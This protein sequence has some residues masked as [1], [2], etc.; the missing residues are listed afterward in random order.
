MFTSGPNLWLSATSAAGNIWE[1]PLASVAPESAP[2]VA[3]ASC[4]FRTST[5]GNDAGTLHDARLLSNGLVAVTTD[6]G[7]KLHSRERHSWYNVANLLPNTGRGT[8]AAIGSTLLVWD[9]PAGALARDLSAGA[10]AK[11]DGSGSRNTLQIIRS[12][13]TLPDSCSTG[14]ARVDTAPDVIAARAFAVDE[15]GKQAYVLKNDG[16]VDLVGE[17]ATVSRI[18]RESQ[19]PPEADVGTRLALP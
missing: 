11:A 15:R 17:T 13:I 18:A 8:L 7:L 19:G 3:T 6:A 12:G 1:R 10:L 4:L 16:G 9:S 5:A 14:P 2:A